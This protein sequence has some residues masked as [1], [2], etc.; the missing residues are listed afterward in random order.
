MLA[1]VKR[2][3]SSKQTRMMCLARRVRPFF[4]DVVFITLTLSSPVNIRADEGN[5]LY[6]ELHLK[7]IQTFSEFKI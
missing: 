7:A 5:M 2:S 3:N 4:S 1:A 6:F